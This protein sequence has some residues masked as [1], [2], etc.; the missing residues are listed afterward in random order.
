MIILEEQPNQ[1][2]TV[3]L[4]KVQIQPLIL[5]LFLPLY[6]QWAISFSLSVT[7]SQTPF[8]L[9]PRQRQLIQKKNETFRLFIYYYYYF[10]IFLNLFLPVT[11]VSEDF[12]SQ[13]GNT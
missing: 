10:V 8:P 7:N 6:H 4:N 13:F 1:I 9:T 5:S 11:I 12:E 3:H 2:S